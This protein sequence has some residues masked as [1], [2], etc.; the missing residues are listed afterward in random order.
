MA[1]AGKHRVAAVAQQEAWDGQREALR[2][3]HGA[4]V[5]RDD[6]PGGEAAHPQ[7]EDV[8]R[9]LGQGAARHTLLKLG[10]FF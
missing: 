2:P 1:L 10:V 6:R 8:R 9:G 7:R 3:E 5:G 4:E